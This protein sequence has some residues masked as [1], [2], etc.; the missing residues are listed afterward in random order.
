MEQQNRLIQEQPQRAEVVEPAT[1]EE[2]LQMKEWIR[3][4]QSDSEWARANSDQARSD[5]DELRLLL[6]DQQR[7]TSGT[8]IVTAVLLLAL[9]GT[10]VYA[11]LALDGHGSELSQL[12]GLQKTLD[13][14]R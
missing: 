2:Y 10:I 12:P 5:V 3:R 7:K 14:D 8:A 6:Q 9:L 11:Y 1:P 4:A 13:A